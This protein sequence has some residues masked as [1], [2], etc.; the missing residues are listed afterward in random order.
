MIVV[1]VV[2]K[3]T[4]LK[5]PILQLINANCCCC[6]NWWWNWI[7]ISLTVLRSEFP[8]SLFRRSTSQWNYAWPRSRTMRERYRNRRSTLLHSYWVNKTR[9]LSLS[10]E[11][12]IVVSKMY[13]NCCFK[14]EMKMHCVADGAR[15]SNFLS[16]CFDN[17]RAN[18]IMLD[19]GQEPCA[20][21]V[22]ADVVIFCTLT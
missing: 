8:L 6:L 11:T 2:Y 20:N 19:Q 22:E 7:S 15:V 3:T 4:H 21:D 14:V 12:K 17:R 16:P 10:T 1:A 9:N 18:G 13:A 5:S